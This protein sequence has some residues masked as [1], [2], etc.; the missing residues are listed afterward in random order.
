MPK[1]PARRISPVTSALTVIL[2][3]AAPF[4]MALAMLFVDPV[5]A[6]GPALESDYVRLVFSDPSDIAR[7]DKKIDFG[8]SGGWFVSSAPAEVEKR[9]LRKID[10]IYDKVQRI[11][12]M[13]KPQQRKVLLRVFHDEEEL[14]ATFLK[15]FKRQGSARAWYV[16]EYNTIY[17][18]VQDVNEGMLAHELAHS[19]IDHYLTVRPPRASAEI[20]ATYVDK[21]LFD[22]VKARNDLQ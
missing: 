14:A 17:I 9:L 11:L 6:A 21:Y 15:I 22:D 4:T 16:Y 10:A 19:I 5:W 2:A 7:L 3:L 8:D 13:R 18:N 1:S 20:L 12:D